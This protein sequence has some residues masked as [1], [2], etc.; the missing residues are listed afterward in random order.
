M[1]NNERKGEMPEFLP[2]DLYFFRLCREAGV[3]IKLDTRIR[4]QHW[5]AYNY[6]AAT[7]SGIE[8]AACRLNPPPQ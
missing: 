6:D 4:L 5:G 2:E 8:E 7:V 3:S 1:V